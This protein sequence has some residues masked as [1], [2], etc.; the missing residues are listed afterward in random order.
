[1]SVSNERVLTLNGGSSSIKF[2]VYGVGDLP[3]RGL[4][5]AFTAVLGGLKT[6]VFSGGI[7]EE[8]PEIRTRVC[9]SLGY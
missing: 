1:M 9:L 6:L 7:G 5:G 8:A 2:A 3:K 4:Y